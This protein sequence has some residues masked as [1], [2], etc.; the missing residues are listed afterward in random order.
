MNKT[1]FYDL[2]PGDL[3]V[4]DRGHTC[5]KV[6]ST[7]ARM[8]TL[9]ALKLKGVPKVCIAVVPPQALVKFIPVVMEVL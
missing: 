7:T 9:E 5:T 1:K 6:T 2:Q 3:F 4:D 8:H